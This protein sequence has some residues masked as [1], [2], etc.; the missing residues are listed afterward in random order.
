[1]PIQAGV[2]QPAAITAEELAA[3]IAE[4]DALAG[5]LRVA[6]AERDLALERLRSLQRQLF[7][8]KSE[9]TQATL[10]RILA[11]LRSYVKRNRISRAFVFNGRNPVSRL[12]ERVCA[13][14]GIPVIFLEYFGKRDDR[15]TY[16]RIPF[17]IFD[18]DQLGDWTA[19]QYAAAGPDREA[20]AEAALQ[21]RIENL[22]PLL[23]SWNLQSGID[24]AAAAQPQ[25]KPVIS[26][27]F[28]SEDEY[29]ALKPSRHGLP[30]PTR[31]H[32]TFRRICEGIAARGLANAYQWEVKLHPRYT[33][34]SAKLAE[35]I[36]AW[37]RAL[38]D[39]KAMGLDII[40]H[41]PTTSPYGVIARSALVISY[42]STAWEACYLGKPGVL[43]GPG[44]F[45]GHGCVYNGGSVEEVLDYIEHIPP[46]LPRE[47][48]YPYAWAW[49][50][51][52]QVPSQFQQ[53]GTGSGLWG[54]L[55]AALGQR[56]VSDG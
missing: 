13:E 5:L 45:G 32:E 14:R 41:P 8:A 24:P 47:K 10:G 18:L 31:Q 19:D 42:G 2:P 56:F 55:R 3:L 28:S 1:M 9:A 20:I 15:M 46:A 25:G 38:A 37:Q 17:D 33:A 16:L 27:F 49:N 39:V 51:L 23:K 35:A 21:D 40:V 50:Q 34:E 43:L 29:P 6:A 22:D 48:A 53:I 4:R 30:D 11:A 54:K 26:F 7:A 12:L 44:P 52:G 36:A